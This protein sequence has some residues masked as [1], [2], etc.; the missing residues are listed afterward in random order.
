MSSV[1]PNMPPNMPPG[2]GVPP[3]DPKTQWRVYREQQKAAWRAQRDAWKTQQHV[4]KASYVGAY[5]PRVPSV[6]GPVILIG[7]GIVALL[8]VTG[9]INAG[10]FWTWYGRWWPLLLIGAGLALLGE[11]ALDMRRE[12]PI[13]RGGSFIGILFLLAVLGLGATGWNNFWG[14]LRAQWGDQGDNFFNAF[15]LPEHTNDQ[16][17]LNSQIPAN[18]TIEIQNPRGDVSVTAGDQSSIQVQAHEVAFARSDEEANK[19]FE[20]EKPRLTVS[21]SAVLV[22]S[23]S[24]NSG[25]LNLTVTVPRTAKVIVNSAHGDVTAAGLGNGINITAAHGDI[26]LGTLTGQVN[27]HFSDHKGDFSAHQ[28]EGDIIA[29]GHCNDI[30]LSEIKGK[31]SINGEIFGDVHMESVSGPINLH[32]SVTDLQVAS[33]PGDLTL[34]PDDLRVTEA[35][36]QVRITTHSK[37]VDLN[38][39]YGDSYVENRDGR[40]AIEPAGIYS[41]EAKNGKGDVEVS[42]PPNASATV[43]GRTRNGDIV[44]EFALAISG[45]ESKTI[46]GRIGS[47]G[48]RITLN[49]QNGDLRIKKGSAFPPAPPAPNAAAAPTAPNAPHL[50][51]HK[52]LPPQPITQ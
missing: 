20:A 22:K 42:L 9:H 21:G 16:V 4:W 51:A 47:G 26:H 36:G 7:V 44:S 2:G 6:V 3:Y 27:A 43:D 48:S 35:K 25:R 49:A 46:S 32:T 17:A 39:I 13:R 19:I 29:D 15:G 30:T 8:V 23:D 45:E 50:K 34:N 31:V 40:I 18:A 12:T 11:W 41:V 14:P 38:Q 28:V 24:S 5:G 37:D 1:P 10:D 33:L 52:V